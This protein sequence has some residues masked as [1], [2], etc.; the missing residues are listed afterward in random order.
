MGRPSG[1]GRPLAS[2]FFTLDVRWM[3]RHGYLVP[4][5]R[6]IIGQS[7]N[8]RPDGQCHI[9]HGGAGF[10]VT[11]GGRRQWIGLDYTPQPFGGQRAWFEC[12][13]CGERC[14]VLYAPR[15]A[16]SRFACR[17]CWGVAYQSQRESPRYRPMLRARK[18]RQ[19]LGGSASMLDP[20]PARP[21]GMHQA[22]YDRL[23]ARD[24]TF[25]AAMA[26]S[27]PQR[28]VSCAKR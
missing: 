16:G 7:L 21:Y 18:I 26:A 12:P 10:D 23:R 24:I 20:F 6:G 17:P 14:G 8:G 25:R 28:L 3:R 5:A 2:H 19:Q 11:I 4:G 27:F 15:A 9:V 13:G 1:G 22:T